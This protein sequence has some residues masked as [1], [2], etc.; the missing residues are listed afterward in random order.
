MNYN[1]TD[2]ESLVL[3][4]IIGG[5]NFKKIF[6]KESEE[7]AKIK[8]GYRPNGL[9]ESAAIILAKKNIDKP[10]IRNYINQQME[11][12]LEQIDRAISEKGD[13]IQE[14]EQVLAEALLDS[15]FSHNVD[16][17]FKL[18]G[19]QVTSEYCKAIQERMNEM[20]MAQNTAKLNVRDDSSHM[21]D[22]LNKEIE[23]LHRELEAVQEQLEKQREEH[24][25]SIQL[26]KQNYAE[27]EREHNA[28]LEELQALRQRIQFEDSVP[29]DALILADEF[30]FRSLC[31]VLEPDYKGR[32]CISRLADISRNGTIEVFYCDEDIPKYFANRTKLFCRDGD[33]PEE[34]GTVAI[35][36]WSAIP[37]NTDSTRD[38][39]TTCFNK[40]I[41]PVEV[42]SFQ[43]FA[44]L[45]DLVEQLKKGVQIEVGNTK[46]LF[47]IY[48]S[49][50]QYEGV[51]CNIR[52][53]E[54]TAD[55]RIRLKKSIISLPRYEFENK[56]I[57]RMSNGRVYY[58]KISLGIPTE[59]YCVVEP[60]EIVKTVI[61]SKISRSDFKQKGKTKNDW[62]N[63]RDF[64]SELDTQSVVKEIRETCLCSDSEADCLLKEFL[65]CADTYIDGNSIEDQVIAS[66]IR[67]NTDLLNRC[68]SM[69]EA[70]W[71]AEHQTEI[72]E[73]HQRLVEIE[74]KI[75]DTEAS[76]KVEVNAAEKR[77]SLLIEEC[78]ALE[79]QCNAFESEIRE[80]QG[81]AVDVENSVAERIKQAQENVADFIAKMAFTVQPALAIGV[82][83][84]LDVGEKR[85]NYHSGIELPQ[86]DLE[87]NTTWEF[88]LDTAKY[89]LIEA[90]VMEQYSRPLAGYLYSAFLNHVPIILV[91]PNASNVADAFSVALFGKTA[92][93]LE[94]EGGYDDTAISECI[95]SDDVIVKILNP[96]Q[97]EWI[98]RIPEIVERRQTYFFAICP[99]PEDVQIESKSLFNYLLPV[100]T[101]VFIEHMPTGNMIGGKAA[102]SFEEFSLDI[103]NTRNVRIP[104]ILRM[105][106]LVKNYMRL[107]LVN[108]HIMLEDNSNDYDLMF[109][110]LPYVVATMQISGL[111][112]RLQDREKLKL[113]VSDGLIDMIVNLYGEKG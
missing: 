77:R 83:K 21:V 109:A 10:F 33:G 68:K 110:Y 64:F 9:S 42:V 55:N 65:V 103:K 23:N 111:I 105:N 1:L 3:C 35:W 86:N 19:I 69:I 37:N 57:V 93:I 44:E 112:E 17:F 38:Y 104:G 4:E 22:K 50:G 107:L 27:L 73:A 100:Y 94:C 5:R 96:F 95:K 40:D 66:V 15:S 97:P 12:W 88:A 45:K 18:K 34:P 67:R 28:A 80:K 14:Y 61:M 46:I 11:E 87:E 82:D 30:E 7:F 51:L 85:S 102:D 62:R 52:D 24:Y 2:S 76:L 99:Y 13:E 8:S 58:K 74:K 59:I 60:L 84:V 113:R 91:G 78:N 101:E 29:E 98:I 20:S 54:K 71:K 16:M 41:S 92:G 25:T 39:V 49:K 79:A 75:S 56:N 48:L 89:E 90:G 106:M 6:Q 81:L 53:L 26:L 32:K 72:D 43:E 31:E 63:V 47:A 70:E 108:M 36:D